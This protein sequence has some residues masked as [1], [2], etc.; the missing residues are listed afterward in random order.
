MGQSSI[1]LDQVG[2]PRRR[3]TTHYHE[4]FELPCWPLVHFAAILE[5]TFGPEAGLHRLLV[6]LLRGFRHITPC[7]DLGLD[8]E[9][10]DCEKGGMR[11]DGVLWLDDRWG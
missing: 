10:C 1:P 5:R 4:A 3:F 8:I 2:I 7:F 11:I 9:Q 6:S